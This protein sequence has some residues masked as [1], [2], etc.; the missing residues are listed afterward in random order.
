M[1]PLGQRRRDFVSW[2]MGSVCSKG[3]CGMGDG[4][5]HSGMGGLLQAQLGA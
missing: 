5:G 2:D 1:K 4:D 3:L